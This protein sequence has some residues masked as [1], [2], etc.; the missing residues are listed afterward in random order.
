MGFG[1]DGT[2]VILRRKDSASLGAMTSGQVVGIG[3]LGLKKDFRLLKL[4]VSATVEGLTQ[5]EGTRLSL[6][7]AN[8]E[9][10]GAEVKECLEAD[11]PLDRSDRVKV[12]RANRAVWSIGMAHEFA[13]E[14]K[15]GFGPPGEV[16]VVK[17]RWT[18]SEVTDFTISVHLRHGT[19]TTGATLNV[20]YTAY[21]VWV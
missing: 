18:F 5:G 14:L 12:E 21:G 16:I 4:E 7:L 1:K 15:V 2:G 6:L 10:S 13:G 17:P 9:L 11:G 8:A 3:P 20:S 19:I